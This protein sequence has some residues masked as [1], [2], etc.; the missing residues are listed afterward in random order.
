[1]TFCLHNSRVCIE[2]KM[3][4]KKQLGI[5]LAIRLGIPILYIV[6]GHFEFPAAGPLEIFA[7]NSKI[8]FTILIKRFD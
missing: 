4:D 8:S 1:M 3:H 5:H 6:N 2:K 7:V